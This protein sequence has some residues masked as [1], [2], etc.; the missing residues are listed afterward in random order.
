MT[1]K[2]VPSY[3]SKPS[4]KLA[5]GDLF[6]RELKK[7]FRTCAETPRPAGKAGGYDCS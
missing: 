7:C 2:D 4:K 5:Y 1:E 6:R 3:H